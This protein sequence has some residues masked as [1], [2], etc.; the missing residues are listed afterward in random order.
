MYLNYAN[1]TYAVL[2]ILKHR[3]DCVNRC[4]T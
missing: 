3:Y 4:K 2:S 1:K